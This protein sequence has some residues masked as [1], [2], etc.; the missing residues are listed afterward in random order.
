MSIK[1][2][3]S[4]SIIHSSLYLITLANIIL[5]YNNANTKGFTTYRELKENSVRKLIN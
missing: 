3:I 4:R 2:V 5:Q 1:F